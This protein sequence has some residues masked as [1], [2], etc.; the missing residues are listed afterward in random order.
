MVVSIGGMKCI[1]WYVHA[2]YVVHEDFRP[3]FSLVTKFGQGSTIIASLKQNIK[4]RSSTEYELVMVDYFMVVILCAQK[5]LESQGCAI[6]KHLL[7][8]DNNATMLLEKMVENAFGSTV[9]I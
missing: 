3:H 9:I 5:F 8:Q 1:T 2:S 6:L 4:T 7:Y